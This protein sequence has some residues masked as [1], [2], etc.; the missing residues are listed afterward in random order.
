MNGHRYVIIKCTIKLLT[1]IYFDKTIAHKQTYCTVGKWLS[2][3]LKSDV[4]LYASPSEIFS[5]G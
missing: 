1:K 2:K 4:L 3:L 5:D